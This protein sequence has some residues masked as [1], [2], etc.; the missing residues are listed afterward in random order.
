M[1]AKS[2][3]MV[4]SGDGGDELFMGYG[5]Y[6]WAQRFSKPVM[7]TSAQ[8][9][10]PLLGLGNSR[11]KRVSKLMNTSNTGFLPSHIFSQEQYFFSQSELNSKFFLKKIEPYSFDLLDFNRKLSDAEKQAYFDMNVYLRDDLLLK[12]DL[13][14]MQ[15]SLE[16][17]VPLLD[18]RLVEFAINLPE[19]WKI[20]KGNQKHFLKEILFQYLPRELYNRPKWGF[21]I[22]L[23]QWLKSDLAY[24]PQKYLSKSVVEAVGFVKYEYVE[25]LLKRFNKGEDYLYNRIWVLIL[26]HRFIYTYSYTS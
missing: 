13:A 8:M 14:S 20:N 24:L 15:N 23:G 11:I 12:V 9:V 10:S 19:I 17:R 2:V 22:P 18:H 3:K 26:L 16:A 5:S 25:N 1:A 7:K 4:L 21:G 6:K